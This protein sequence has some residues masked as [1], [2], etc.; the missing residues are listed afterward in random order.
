VHILIADDDLTSRS[1][2][3]DIVAG[4]EA[5][6]NDYI[7]QPFDMGELRARLEVGKRMIEMQE[8]LALKIDEFVAAFT[9]IRTLH[10]LLPICAS[11]KKIRS[12][13]GAW[14][15]VEIYV[16]K[17]TEARFTHCICPECF[18]KLYPEYS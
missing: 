12:G 2:K 17:N 5:G 4:L 11:C 13:G 8:A 18:E 6:A 16:H 15:E 9:E 14:E 7:S 3:T 1:E 10:G